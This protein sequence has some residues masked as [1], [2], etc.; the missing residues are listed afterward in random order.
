MTE[1]VFAGE[2]RGVFHPD[3]REQWNIWHRHHEGKRVVVVLD[4]ERRTRSLA[5]NRRYWS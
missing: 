1:A 4:L 2:V 3:L 5:A